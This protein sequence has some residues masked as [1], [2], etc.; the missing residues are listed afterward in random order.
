MFMQGAALWCK[1]QEG[2]GFK[3]ASQLGPFC[4]EF[5]WFPLGALVLPKD[6]RSTSYSKFVCV[7]EFECEWL[8]ISLS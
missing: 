2:S 3:S 4:S 7:C 5:A 1:K 8:F 6:I